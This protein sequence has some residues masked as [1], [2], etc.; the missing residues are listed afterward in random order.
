ML[1][2]GPAEHSTL[3]GLPTVALDG[4]VSHCIAVASTCF[5]KRS[6]GLSRVPWYMSHLKKFLRNSNV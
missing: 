2:P 5:T 4:L 3:H 6:A 1:W